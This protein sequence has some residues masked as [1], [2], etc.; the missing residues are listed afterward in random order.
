LGITAKA[1]KKTL[2]AIGKPQGVRGADAP[3]TSTGTN[4][5]S[6]PVP[7]TYA[8]IGRFLYFA[9]FFDLIRNLEGDVVECGVGRGDSFVM[10]SILAKREG[11]GR[12]VWGFDSFEG[13]PSPTE[14]DESPRNPQ[15]GEW[16]TDLVDVV[17][18]LRLAGLDEHFNNRQATLVKGFFESSLQLFRGKKIALLHLDCDLYR[19]Y[20]I[21]L[22]T[23]YPLVEPGGIVAFDE[24]INTGQLVSFP[25]AQRAIDEFFGDQVHRIVSDR[26]TGQYHLVKPD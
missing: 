20:R 5:V 2:R 6:R 13:F 22:E 21:C 23:L 24:Y 19:S 11:A 16:K 12:R 14:E 10:L 7:M 25:G 15:R 17:Q 1:L 26:E 4:E 18:A 9:R 8:N 3:S